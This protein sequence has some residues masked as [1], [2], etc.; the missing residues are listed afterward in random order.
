MSGEI[1]AILAVG[2]AL[3]GVIPPEGCTCW[4]RRMVHPRV[5]GGNTSSIDGLLGSFGTSPRVRGKPLQGSHYRPWLRSDPLRWAC[6]GGC[7]KMGRL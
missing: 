3:A 6:L 7:G 5:C 1:I 2:G 4:Y